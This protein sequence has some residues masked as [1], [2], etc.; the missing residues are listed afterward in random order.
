M[1]QKLFT[2]PYDKVFQLVPILNLKIKGE[3]RGYVLCQSINQSY[4]YLYVQNISSVEIKKQSCY[5]LYYNVVNQIRC[6][7]IAEEGD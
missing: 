1:G 3:R 5:I 6:I 7:M 4:G 2:I